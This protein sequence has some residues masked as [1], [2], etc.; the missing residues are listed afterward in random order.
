MEREKELPVSYLYD[1][2]T[3]NTAKSYLGFID[4]IV[5]PFYETKAKCMPKMQPRLKVYKENK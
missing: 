4:F 1:R 3:V 5:K 2:I